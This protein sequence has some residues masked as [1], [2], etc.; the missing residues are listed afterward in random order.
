M[1]IITAYATERC[2]FLCQL[3]AV[4]GRVLMPSFLIEN[5][6]HSRTL[7]LWP[8]DVRVHLSNAAF[9]TSRVLFCPQPLVNLWLLLMPPSPADTERDPGVGFT[10]DRRLRRRSD[11]KPTPGRRAVFSRVRFRCSWSRGIISLVW[12]DLNEESSRVPL[13]I[14]KSTRG[15]TMLV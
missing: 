9:V 2:F 3:D 15:D 11:V 12:W 8:K 6:G 7:L 5:R 13:T 14:W 4:A 10:S 1:Y